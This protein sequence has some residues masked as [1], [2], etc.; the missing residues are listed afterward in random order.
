MFVIFITQIVK[1]DP[2]PRQGL[3]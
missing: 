2:K 1:S 3:V